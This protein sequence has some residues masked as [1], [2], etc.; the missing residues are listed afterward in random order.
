M[1]TILVVD[2]E[3][4]M[5]LA[6]RNTLELAGYTVLDCESGRLA[7]ETLGRGGVDL[8]L[9][10][11]RLPDMDGVQ[12]LKKVKADFPAVPVIMVTGFGSL[13]TAVQT[14]QVGAAD[15]VSKPFQNKDLFQ[16][17]EKA[18]SSRD[19]KAPSGPITQR[20]LRDIQGVSKE[21]EPLIEA[22]RRPMPRWIPWAG[23]GAAVLAA[24]GF[25][26]A[27]WWSGGEAAYAI[28]TAHLSGISFDGERL[29]LADWYAQTVYEGRIREDRVEV[30]KSFH[31]DEVRP[32]GIASSGD[33]LYISD[34]WSKKVSKHALDGMLSMV[35]GAASAGPSP[36]G[37]F[38]EGKN[39]WCADAGDDK[40]FRLS[41]EE[42]FRAQRSLKTQGTAPVGAAVRNGALW[43]A[44]ADT[45]RLYLHKIDQDFTPM[46]VYSHPWLRDSSRPL[47]AFMVL[48]DDVWFGFEGVERLYR[49]RIR[50][51]RKI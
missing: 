3:Q 16:R 9:L 45:K 19:L 42:G 20:L 22:P 31:L 30:L 39:L 48:G 7:L 18:L 33:A 29:W 38:L 47:S 11:I 49:V 15:Y 51:L 34:S 40:V 50:K 17:I 21:P 12:I 23:A 43:I 41:P 36:A 1:A 32:T 25:F 13:E 24:A 35:E 27:R 2:D 8:M 14:V 46:A 44:D 26:F 28:P 5:R 6:L 37:L 10:D 4:D